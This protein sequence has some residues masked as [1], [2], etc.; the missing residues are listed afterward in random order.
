MRTKINA[1]KGISVMKIILNL[2]VVF[3]MLSCPAA[4][5]NILHSPVESII[6]QGN[7]T[8]IPPQGITIIEGRS[9]ILTAQLAPDGV[10]GGIHWQSSNHNIVE[11][12]S[13]SGQ[14]IT[15][16][17]KSEGSTVI[18]VSARNTFN[19]LIVQS[20][21][22]I[23]VIPRSFFKWNYIHTDWL[24]IPVLQALTN[25]YL[26][27]ASRPILIR[28]GMTNIYSDIILGGI[29]LE[30]EGAQLIIGSG[31]ATATNSPFADHPVYDRNSQF[32]FL[33]GP[34][35]YDLWT[36]RVR[37]CVEYEILDTDTN[38]SLLRIQVNNNTTERFNASAINNWLVAEL[39]PS[40]ARSGTLT[41]VFD[42]SV[43]RLLT[44]KSSGIPG[45]SEEAKLQE[46]LS[47]SFVC[48]SLPDGRILI[49]SIRID[50]AD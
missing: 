22:I 43:S 5:T 11:M 12:S 45:S 15:I 1:E 8:P 16:T 26:H 29:I 49:R 7:R 46:V 38:K 4:Q 36:G 3:L 30:G 44:E 34:K 40:C 2:C 6:I 31:M 20:E 42:N 39:S 23:T 21:C 41:G 50:S 28:T 33:N 24:E 25:Y 37:I 14:E 13:L 10:Q 35:G 17:G 32:D 47:S 48:L 27:D 19:D 9:V 18:F